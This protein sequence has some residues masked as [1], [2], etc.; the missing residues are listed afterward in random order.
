[1]L[2]DPE[3]MCSSNFAVDDPLVVGTVNDACIVDGT[4]EIVD[5]RVVLDDDALVVGVLN[6][7]RI[8]DGTIEVADVRV[9]LYDDLLAVGVIRVV[10]DTLLVGTIS[11]GRIVDGTM[12]VV[13][14]RVELD[15]DAL[16][17]RDENTPVGVPV[18]DARADATVL[19]AFAHIGQAHLL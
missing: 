10:L 4:V 15:D 12:E 19:A 9:V 16:T 8:V 1:M 18:D 3:V 17:A 7:A 11:D 14:V 6:D 2:P 13:D 5:V